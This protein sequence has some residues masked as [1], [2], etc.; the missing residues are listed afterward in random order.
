MSSLAVL[1]PSRTHFDTARIVGS[2][3]CALGLL[4]TPLAAY[5]VD[6]ES[7]P[8]NPTA[9]APTE[10][11][12]PAETPAAAPAPAEPAPAAPAVIAPVA[13]V[14]TAV[15]PTEAPAPDAAATPSVS[16]E[17]KPE[18]KKKFW[19]WRGS[20]SFRNMTS[21]TAFDQSYEQSYLPSETLG[22]LITPRYAFN[23]TMSIG[24]WQY[25]TVELTNTANTTYYREPTLSDTIVSFAWT[26]LNTAANAAKDDKPTSAFVLSVQGV[27]GLPTS[28]ASLAK[29]LY[30]A[31][32]IGVGGRYRWHDLTVGLTTR[33]QHSF[34]KSTTMQYDAQP[35][36]TC[37]GEAFGCSPSLLSSGVR[38]SE[39]RILAIGSLGYSFTE[40]LSVSLSAGEIMDWVPALTSASV[41][42]AGV[43]KVDV[44]AGDDQRFR[45][46]MYWG[47]GVDYSILPWLGAGI[48]IE[49]Y[50]SQ[51]KLDSTYE[52]PMINRYTTA[53]VELSVALDGLPH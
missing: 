19:P 39:N 48:G 31:P 46:L 52:T 9:P 44:P 4:L 1:I 37:T 14:P 8:P 7:A 2:A 12:K 35:I 3:V 29:N 42:V 49:T 26:A 5:A 33:F 45:A 18:E 40:K 34:Y 10:P 41:P 20:V 50:N 36:T 6:P 16:A 30:V 38:S 28:K 23:D 21:L 32:G 17:A 11:T 25:A 24:L 51:L 22:A 43:G 47:A 27:L 15:T 13:I 53:Y